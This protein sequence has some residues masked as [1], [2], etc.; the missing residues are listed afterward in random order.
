MKSMETLVALLH[1]AEGQETQN[2]AE[3]ATCGVWAHI[4]VADFINSTLCNMWVG[5]SV[6]EPV[7]WNFPSTWGWGGFD[8]SMTQSKTKYPW[9]FY[10]KDA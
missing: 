10:F 7:S 9:V 5:R 6:N 3:S 2:D 4:T 1:P 8:F